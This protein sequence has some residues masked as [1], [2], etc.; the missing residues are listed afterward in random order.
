MG[1]ENKHARKMK[2]RRTGRHT[3]PSPVEKAAEKAGKAAPAMAVAGVI[4]AAPQLPAFGSA[5]AH[6][7]VAE[8]P[9]H[10]Q[11]DAAIHPAATQAT[12]QTNPSSYTVASGDTL[13]SIAQRLYGKTSD[14][15]WLY[16]ANQS[17]VHD[18]NLI[19][20][21]E[22]LRLPSAPPA[23]STTA[24]AS[25]TSTSSSSS[26]GSSGTTAAASSTSL[27]GTLG[28]SGLEQLWEAAG[29]SSSAA[30]TAASI[31]IA[32]S[33]GN[34]YATGPFGERGY[35]QINP[36][37]GS[38]STYNPLG[39]AKAAVTMSHDGSNWSAWTT[40]TTGAYQGKC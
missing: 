35:W 1:L 24:T 26:S 40:F 6:A 22:V 21:G 15:R 29:G 16:D 7:A 33:S 19:Y 38:L 9:V 10:A 4:V 30:V 8:Q 25:A 36:V 34:Q 12:E 39:N 13:S 23:S 18:A 11:L 5:P 37:N 2:V 28:C 27:S 3:T 14:W 17:V 32:E 31:A 20:P